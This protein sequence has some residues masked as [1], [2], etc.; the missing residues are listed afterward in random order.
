M[1]RWIAA[2]LTFAAC[3]APEHHPAPPPGPGAPH[4]ASP[5]A[6]DAG[7]PV[8]AAIAVAPPDAAPPAAADHIELTFMGDIMF[9]GTFSGHW[10]PED[11]CAHDPLSDMAP[12]YASDLA[13]ANLETTVVDDIPEMKGDRRFAC[14]PAQLALLPQEGIG[15]VTVANNHIAD[16]DGPGIVETV[17]HLGESGLQF[18]GAPRTEDPLFK[19]EDIEVKGWKIGFI[20]A[21]TKLNRHQKKGDPV[22]PYVAD[23]KDLKDTLVPVVEAARADHDLVIVVMHWGVQYD[24]APSDWQVEAAHAFIDAG[25][26]A[27]IGHH[28]HVMQGIERYKNGVIAYS[29][30]NF[31]F[32]NGD[33]IARDT[34]VVRLGFSRAGKCIDKVVFHPAIVKRQPVHHPIPA[35]DKDFT[36]VSKRLIKLSKAK[37]LETEWTVDGDHL[38]AEAACA[39]D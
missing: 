13:L 9:N 1:S 30:G 17:Q 5:A 35:T 4:P 37:P 21:T 23:P 10:S 25:A 24:D 7:V 2:V 15:A 29:L 16:L 32:Q 22:V 3:S 8:D 11:V 18:I 6:P 20:A 36:E 28:P 14:T 33:A 27:V 34:G 26:D 38:T 12:V 39:A 31:V 19:V